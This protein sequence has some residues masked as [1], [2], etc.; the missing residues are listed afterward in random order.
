[1]DVPPVLPSA[2]SPVNVPPTKRHGCLMTWLVVMLIADAGGIFYQVMLPAIQGAMGAM[3]SSTS[4]GQLTPHAVPPEPAW[5][6]VAIIALCT[7]DIVAVAGVYYWKRWGF[8]AS[9]GA[10]VILFAINLVSGIGVVNSLCYLVSPALLY[11]TL[12]LG[13]E[14]CG[15][16]R[17]K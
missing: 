7:V 6:V 16:R 12:K 3:Q 17:L 13:G 15:W 1:M 9:V 8:Y 10:S 14:N 4:L 11:A 5:L 2:P